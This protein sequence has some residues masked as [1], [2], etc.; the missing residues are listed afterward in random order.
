MEHLG[1]WALNYKT[2]AGLASWA[3][4]IWTFEQCT[5]GGMAGRWSPPGWLSGRLARA[6]GSGT[7]G[8]LLPGCAKETGTE[9][10]RRLSICVGWSLIPLYLPHKQQAVVPPLAV[11]K[12]K[13]EE[14]ATGGCPVQ[15]ACSSV[16]PGLGP[17]ILPSPL[18]P[19]GQPLSC[20]AHPLAPGCT[21]QPI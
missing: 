9:W 2:E 12:L 4:G 13:A 1:S 7:G 16:S 17:E 15:S 18:P 14:P 11:Q 20:R 8:L 19:M 10:H 21:L 6:P 3:L 5:R